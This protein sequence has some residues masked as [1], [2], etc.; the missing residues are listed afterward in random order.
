MLNKFLE[1]IKKDRGKYNL[2]GN[3]DNSI[4]I[5]YQDSF[6]ELEHTPSHILHIAQSY[7]IHATIAGIKSKYNVVD[8]YQL[9]DI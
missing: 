4:R 2:I 5:I 1:I 7:A 3:L 6:F 9:G 8:L